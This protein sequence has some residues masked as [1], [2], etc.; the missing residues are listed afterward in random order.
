M[1]A[2][3]MLFNPAVIMSAC[4]AAVHGMPEVNPR[5]RAL[6]ALVPNHTAKGQPGT[7]GVW[8]P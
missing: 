7:D 6:N 2:P 5:P 1:A 3:A 8:H 4:R